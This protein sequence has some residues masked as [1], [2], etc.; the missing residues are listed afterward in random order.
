[1]TIQ[2]LVVLVSLTLGLVVGVVLGRIRRS[3]GYVS[4]PAL[5]LLIVIA[6]LI[7][8][9]LSPPDL[10][11]EIMSPEEGAS[12]GHRYT[13]QGKVSDPS[14]L[15][16]VLIHPLSTNLWYVQNRPAVRSDGRWSTIIY[17]GT[18]DGEGI[19]DSYEVVA[20]ATD[21]NWFLRK[22][23]GTSLTSGQRLKT[24]PQHGSNIDT[25]MV[26]RTE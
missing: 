3:V 11:V 15:V 16:Y 8:V 24:I 5:M 9:N 7:L 26:R 10:D 18:I 6:F 17:F 14:A 2:L 12:V 13:I 22:L 19:G 4:G 21:E 25:V 1:M 23:R 20:L